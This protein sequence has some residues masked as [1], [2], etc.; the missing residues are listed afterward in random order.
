MKKKLLTR[1]LCCLLAYLLLVVLL[2][3]AESRS[4]ASSIRT[5]GDAFWYSLVTL[6]TVGYGDLVPRTAAGRF[7]G[8]LFVCLSIGFLS[9]LIGSFAALAGRHL[10]PILA[11]RIGHGKTR[12]LFT[13]DSP[14]AEGICLELLK[15]K[16]NQVIICAASASVSHGGRCV[17]ITLAPTELP[18]RARPLLRRTVVVLPGED[19]A[20]NLR[21]AALLQEHC[22]R[23]FCLASGEVPG[24]AQR[25]SFFNPVDCCA[26][27]YW[28]E[29]PLTP[30]E[31][32]LLIIGDGPW[33]Q[34]LLE[35]GLLV[36]VLHPEQQLR[37]HVFGNW[38][39]FC[40]DRPELGSV[41]SLNEERSHRDALLCH[42]APW[43]ADP[44]LVRRA[45]RIIICEEDPSRGWQTLCCLRRGFS[46]EAAVYLRTPQGL[47]GVLCFGTTRRLYSP[48]LVFH[49]GLDDR[50]RQLHGLYLR[51]VGKASPAW[52]EL[53]SFAR[54]SNIAAADHLL[55]KLRILLP[56]EDVRAITPE[57]C[58][59]AAESYRQGYE[60]NA[61][62]FEEIEHIRWCRYHYLNGWRYAP[63][64][65]DALRLHPCL[66]PFGELS[67]EEKQKDDN[68]WLQIAQL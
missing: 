7:I 4:P 37:Y 54:D 6:T 3:L 63:E 16:Q 19:E 23:I 46:S 24:F 13:C 27:Q 11:L 53:S 48:E 8:V 2:F 58:Q 67:P 51:S 57:N 35:R 36:N 10:L 5:L 15:D 22:E 65:N 64:R 33:A 26:R 20:E 34:A 29:H 42:D 32:T 18:R 1:V 40:L 25:V 31:E 44:E 60:A 66:V 55:T 50:A 14:I 62:L 61:A 52:D 17:R 68:A 39:D 41:L 28:Q 43:N 9:L 47:P 49:S 12:Y 56:R 59:R 38:Q 21:L 30:G 45:Q